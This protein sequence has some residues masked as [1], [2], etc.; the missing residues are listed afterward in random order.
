MS[1]TASYTD[2]DESYYEC[3]TC[4]YTA[5]TDLSKGTCPLCGDTLTPEPVVE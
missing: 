5:K 1:K 3:I 2:I 4:G